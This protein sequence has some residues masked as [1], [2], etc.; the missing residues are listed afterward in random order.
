M[1]SQ[2][3][4]LR[5]AVDHLRGQ[6]V[7]VGL[8]KIRA[9]RPFPDEQVCRAVRNAAVVVVLDRALS[10]GAEGI[11]AREVKAAL[12]DTPHRPIVLGVLAGYGGREVTVERARAIVDRARRAADGA[13]PDTTPEFLG[14]IRELL[15]SAMGI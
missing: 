6:A 8:V 4:T 1:G 7:K 15:D 14:L 13:D 10:M 3:S 11:L 9:F 2:V 5:Q 12:Y